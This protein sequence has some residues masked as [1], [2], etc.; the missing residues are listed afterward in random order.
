MDMVQCKACG[1]QVAAGAPFCQS[2]G[3][4]QSATAGP[5]MAAPTTANTGNIVAGSAVSLAGAVLVGV[6]PFLPWATAGIMS[7]NG[8]QKT[9]DE[10]I[11]LVL[12]GFIGLL[13]SLVGLT[14]KRAKY[15]WV[16]LLA[17]LVGVCLAGFY[18][19]QVKEQLEGLSGGII[20]PSIG[21]GM[22][23]CLVGSV[24]LLVGGG[25]ALSKPRKG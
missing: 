7:A 6:G 23:A 5:P 20:T 19:M 10:A 15:T 14:Q 12:V 22:Y 18:Y 25:V 21:F 16:T 24:L 11:T 2:C 3:A 4:P 9:G 1:N 13:T 17:G 8:M